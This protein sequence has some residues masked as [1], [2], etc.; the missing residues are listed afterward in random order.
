MEIKVKR[1]ADNGDTTMG[2]FLIND[3]FYCFTIEDEESLKVLIK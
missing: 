2:L 1:F 3:K